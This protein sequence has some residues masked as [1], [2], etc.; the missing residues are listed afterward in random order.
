MAKQGPKLTRGAHPT[1]V[2][3]SRCILSL[4]D[5]RALLLAAALVCPGAIAASAQQAGGRTSAL[6][7]PA[8][9]LIVDIDDVGFDLLRE[10]PTPTLDALERGGR[11]FTAFTT[12]PTCSP[13]RAMFHTGA[14][15]SHPDLLVGQIFNADTTAVMPTAPLVTLPRLLSDT[16]YST[17][18]IGKWHLSGYPNPDHPRDSGYDHYSGHIA[19]VQSGA[20][21][22]YWEYPK[23]VDGTIFPRAPRPY[24]TTA[25]T[26]DA[27][28]AV[29]SGVEFVS[30]SYHAPHGP[31]HEPPAHL[32]T[33]VNIGSDRARARAMLEAL[34]TE[35]RRL[36]AEALPLGYTTV[37][38]ADNGTASQ[39][40]GQKATM[41]DGG[42][43]CPL[44]VFGPGISPGVDANPIGAVDLYATVALWFGVPA[45]IGSG[46]PRR[47]PDSR[48]FLPAWRGFDIA[49]RWT[50]SERF[51]QL[52]EDPRTSGAQ[53][54]RMVRSRRYKLVHDD[55]FVGQRRFHDLHTDPDEAV[56][57]LD[58]GAVLEPAALLAKRTFDYVLG[59]L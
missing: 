35:L 27:I 58:P 12:A 23:V 57:L 18:K 24:I 34:D 50:Y 47:G 14:R 41:Y 19:N 37:V 26:D 28:S 46:E 33:Q 16:G 44:W 13:T 38:F 7:T 30:V 54:R 4:M 11:M 2:R 45:G 39:V 56:N 48:S 53:W 17:S 42:V 40:G 59:R 1:R 29:R 9:M 8:R 49:R 15:C 6:G 55:D 5:R 10:T 36:L 52:G 3:A 51:R 20:S 43:I 22:T 32:H 25:E 31:W 21:E